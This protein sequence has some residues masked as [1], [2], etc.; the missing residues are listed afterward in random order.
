MPGVVGVGLDKQCY[1]RNICLPFTDAHDDMDMRWPRLDRWVRAAMLS[2]DV[3]DVGM[4][5]DLALSQVT[6]PAS[7]RLCPVALK[8]GRGTDRL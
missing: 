6:D 7:V 5:S 3:G 4:S 2:Y 1:G 8:Q